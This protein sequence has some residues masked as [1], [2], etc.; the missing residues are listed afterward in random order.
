SPP[1]LSPYTTLF[2]SVLSTTAPEI[3]ATVVACA[4]RSIGIEQVMATAP[5]TRNHRR[6]AILTAA[7]SGSAR[8]RDGVPGAISPESRAQK[9]RSEEHTS[10]LQSLTN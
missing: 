5:N 6:F 10:E 1:P 3:C 9:P 8:R 4:I 2:R 7:S